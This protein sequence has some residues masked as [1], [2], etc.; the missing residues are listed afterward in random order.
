[1]K[2]I[3]LF[4]QWDDYEL[5]DIFG[6]DPPMKIVKIGTGYFILEKMIDDKT[7]ILFPGYM[8]SGP[9]IHTKTINPN[10]MINVVN[11]NIRLEMGLKVQYAY[12]DLPKEIKDRL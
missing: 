2:R 5:D 10:D 11:N 3:K 12:K 1:M 7:G 9:I 8:Y 4:E 6:K